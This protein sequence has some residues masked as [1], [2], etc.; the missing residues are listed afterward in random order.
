MTSPIPCR[1]GVRR[2]RSM[3]TYR[4]C[5]LLSCLAMLIGP[6]HADPGEPY[7]LAQIG[8]IAVAPA[9]A[10]Q[11]RITVV[12]M[13]ETLHAF[14]GAR[15]E[16]TPEGRTLVLIRCPLKARCRVDLPAEPVAEDPAASTLQLAD[17]GR[18]LVVQ[19]ADGPVPL[20][21]R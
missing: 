1:R 14:A 21:P 8:S 16:S 12:P 20:W 10:S 9:A 6:A 15:V 4:S 19:Y 17:D 2:P 11:I 3:S 7:A 18:A 13:L 5:W